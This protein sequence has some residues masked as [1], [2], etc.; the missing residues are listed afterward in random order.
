MPHTGKEVI[1][2]EVDESGFVPKAKTVGLADEPDAG[3]RKERRWHTR[4][5]EAWWGVNQL[6]SGCMWFEI[7]LG[8]LWKR[9][10]GA[11]ADVR[12]GDEAVGSHWPADT[13]QSPSARHGHLG[14]RRRKRREGSPRQNS[15]GDHAEAEPGMR[16]SV[17]TKGRQ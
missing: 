1:R 5:G 16:P 7:A 9:G 12:A 8:H 13:C 10:S 17:Q 14:Q 15:I 11:L 4:E 2:T 6:L 3:V